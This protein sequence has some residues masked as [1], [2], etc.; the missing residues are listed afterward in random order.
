MINEPDSEAISRRGVLSLLGV[1][2][3]SIA[4]PTVVMV[5]DADAQQSVDPGIGATGTERRLDRREDRTE[6]RQDRRLDRTERRQDRRTGR[7]ARRVTRREG[8]QERRE[9]RRKGREERRE[10]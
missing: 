1:A 5:S 10:M 9:L 7:K 6:R 8:R 2:A 4:A 3:L